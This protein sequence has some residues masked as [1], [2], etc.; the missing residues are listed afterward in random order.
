[1]SSRARDAFWRLKNYFG[2]LLLFLIGVLFFGLVLFTI[3]ENSDFLGGLDFTVAATSSDATAILEVGNTAPTATGVKLNNDTDIVLIAGTTTSVDVSVNITDNNGCADIQNGTTTILVYRSGVTSSTCLTTQNNLNCYLATAFTASSTC[4]GSANSI[5]ATATFGIYYFA[6][7][8]DTSSSYESQNW[9]ATV[10]FKDQ[11]NATGS[12]QS[13]GV[14]LRGL[15]GIEVGTSSIDYG[16]LN[17]STTTGFINQITPIS[18]K[19]NTTTTLLINGTAMTLAANKISTSSQHY[20]TSTFYYGGTEQPLQESATTVSGVSLLPRISLVNDVG[21]WAETMA[22]P[23]SP[24]FAAFANSPY[25][26]YAM[27]GQT[28]TTVRYAAF[29]SDGTIGSWANTTALSS[30][31]FLAGG[32]VYGN[33]VYAVGG[34]GLSPDSEYALL[35]S[36]G[37]VGTWISG[38]SIPTGGDYSNFSLTA[39]YG[40]LFAFGGIDGVSEVAAVYKAQIGSDGSIGTWISTTALPSVLTDSAAVSYN[41]YVYVL[42]GAISSVDT[43]TVRFSS[44]ASSGVLGTWTSTTALPGAMSS[45]GATVLNGYIYVLGESTTSVFYAP[46]NSTGSLGSWTLTTA[47]PSTL[48]NIRAVNNNGYIYGMPNS[49]ATSTV[50]YAQINNGRS[51]KNLFWGLEVPQTPSGAYSGVNTFTASYSP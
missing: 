28:T 16:T 45:F 49:A 37:T 13:S 12:G 4:S 11:T 20:A 9:L 21:S 40:Y 39:E 47:M 42:G 48:T 7:P 2:F 33:Y 1:M 3:Q 50:I 36:N 19:G 51:A 8:T 6:D 29:N 23:S 17:A 32:L 46:I 27:G 26:V 22:L 25:H 5:N 31:R 15:T 38:S 43:S 34:S 35:N 41:G 18:N 30:S 14:E 10:I 24:R 44:V